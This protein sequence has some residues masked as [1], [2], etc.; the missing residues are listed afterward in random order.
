MAIKKGIEP[1]DILWKFSETNKGRRFNRETT[2]YEDYF[3]EQYYVIELASRR[4]R[5]NGFIVTGK[6]ITLFKNLDIKLI[7]YAP[8][9]Y[10]PESIYKAVAVGTTIS[11]ISNQKAWEDLEICEVAKKEYAKIPNHSLSSTFLTKNDECFDPLSIENIVVDLVIP[12]EDEIEW[13]E[14]P[15]FQR[16]SLKTY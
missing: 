8:S 1:G 16:Y 14:E 5:T 7:P 3:Y 6:L 12:Q 11:R 9:S 15:T 13:P 2:Q 4:A 10:S